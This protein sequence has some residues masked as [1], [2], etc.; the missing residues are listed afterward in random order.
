MITM[1]V[2][3]IFSTLQHQA[4]FC[5]RKAV[6]VF[7]RW[8]DESHAVASIESALVFPVMLL[9]LVGV[10]DLGNAIL[11]NQKTIRAS[12]IVADLVTRENIMTDDLL[13]EAVEAGR[14]AFAP[15]SSDSYGIDIVSIRFDENSDS[16]VVWRETVNMTP[17]SDVLGK[18]DSLASPEEGV[19]VVSVVYNYEPLISG[20]A[21][22]AIGMRETAFSRGRSKSV[23]TRE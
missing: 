18:V 7:Y 5:W 16:E 23:I 11:V 4:L 19:V 9:L 15:L 14:L 21:I 2:L 3:F 17:L 22:S 1:A 12:Q 6:C 10:Y 13:F 20:F 8:R